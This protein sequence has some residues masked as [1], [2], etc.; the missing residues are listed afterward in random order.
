[1]EQMEW[2]ALDD[3]SDAAALWKLCSIGPWARGA[4][5]MSFRLLDWT[6][7]ANPPRADRAG[8]GADVHPPLPGR[9][10]ARLTWPREQLTA[11]A[12]LQISEPAPRPI[13]TSD[14]SRFG[15]DLGTCFLVAAVH[16]GVAECLPDAAGQVI[17]PLRCATW[18]MVGGESAR[19]LAAGLDDLSTWSRSSAGGA[20]SAGR[21]GRRRQAALPLR[22]PP[23]HAGHRDA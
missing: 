2:R 9:C 8:A 17:C 6:R 11:M 3:A 12:L 14:V 4:V 5:S 19:A 15:I 20:N 22:R 23:R 1:M 7:P 16:H 21:C 18:A 10:R 13:R